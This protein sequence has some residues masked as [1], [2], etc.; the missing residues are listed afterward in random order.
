M[1]VVFDRCAGLDVHKQ[2]IV[3]CALW[4]DADGQRHKEVRS[5][6]TMTRDLLALSDWLADKAVTHVAMESTGVFWKPVF[7]ILESRFEILLVNARHIKQVPGRKSDVK[8][9]E[10]IAQLL[11]HGLLRGSFVP[12]RPQRELR[13]LT[14]HRAQLMSEHTRIANRIHKILEDAN[15]KLGSVASDIL[16]VSGRAMIEALIAGESDAQQLSSLAR[17]RLKNK[18]AEL[19]GALE[20]HVTPHHRF[21]LK[22]LMD[23]LAF[24]EELVSTMD[25]RIESL[26]T[27]CQEAAQRLMAIPGVNRCVAQALLAEIG[28]D[29]SHFPT[30]EHLASWA[31]LCPGT[32]ESAGKRKSGRTTK[33]CRWLRRCLGQ[34]AWAVSRS[35][36]TYLSAQFRRITRRRG[37]KRAVIAVAHSILVIAYHLLKDNTSYGDLGPNH[38]DTRRAQRLKQYYLNRLNQLGFTVTVETPIEAA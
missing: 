12:D 22:T 32:N 23:H 25:T 37:K 2:T 35:K 28:T 4:E 27:P 18:A 1:D 6:G 19:H 29:M 13:D 20:G 9:C 33:G 8:D 11:Q 14:R 26:M 5:F 34:A 17:G 15:I 16:G 10:W 30:A 21:M 24:L 31:G 36:D 3:A 38:F 7:N